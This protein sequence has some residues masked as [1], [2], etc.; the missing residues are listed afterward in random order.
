MRDSKKNIRALKNGLALNR[1]FNP[2]VYDTK[3]EHSKTSEFNIPGLIPE[4]VIQFYP[5]LVKTNEKG[6]IIGVNYTKIITILISAI[7]ELDNEN[8]LVKE[9][10]Y[11]IEKKLNSSSPD[12][13]VSFL[14]IFRK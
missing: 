8:K 6:D 9:R 4:E 3:Q 12:S 7:Q 1:N 10:L 5:E 14:N 11:N 2:V 13:D